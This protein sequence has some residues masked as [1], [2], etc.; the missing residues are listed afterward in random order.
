[1]R[2][3]KIALVTLVVVG[4][5]LGGYYGAHYIYELGAKAG[6]EYGFNLGATMGYQYGY[7]ECQSEYKSPD[8]ITLPEEK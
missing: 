5:G 7:N 3:I 6:M 2:K 1:M 4:S 8:T